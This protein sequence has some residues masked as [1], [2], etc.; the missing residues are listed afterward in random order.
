MGKGAVDTLPSRSH[1]IILGN[2]FI[3]YYE[4]CLHLLIADN[5]SCTLCVV[6]KSNA[7]RFS[8]TLYNH[9]AH[10]SLHYIYIIP[11]DLKSFFTTIYLSSYKA[12]S[13]VTEYT[14]AY[15]GSKQSWSAS[16]FN[17]KMLS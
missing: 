17:I 6:L 8:C 16:C 13:S 15:A 9:N 4:C 7:V 2:T 10:L 14:H 3:F 12:K 1:F 5:N 11:L